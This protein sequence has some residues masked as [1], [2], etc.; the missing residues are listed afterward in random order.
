M[1]RI[2]DDHSSTVNSVAQDLFGSG[3]DGYN[4]PLVNARPGTVVKAD[5]MNA[6]QNEIA[7][8]I[9]G[10]DTLVDGNTINLIKGDRA[11]L[12]ATLVHH[13]SMNYRAITFDTLG[14]DRLFRGHFELTGGPSSVGRFVIVGQNAQI[15]VSRG[16]LVWDQRVADGAFGGN[17]F[18]VGFDVTIGLWCIVGDSDEIQTSPDGQTWTARTA[19]VGGAFRGVAGTASNTLF[20]AVGVSGIQESS[21][22]GIAWTDRSGATA[23]S[24]VDVATF[25]GSFIAVG[26]NGTIVHTAEGTPGGWATTPAAGG[27][28]GFFRGVASS[29]TR[30]VAVG[31][32]GEIQ[33]SDNVTTWTQANVSAFP[34]GVDWK[35]VEHNG[36]C[37]VVVGGVGATDQFVAVSIDGDNWTVRTLPFDLVEALNVV[38]S[39]V[40]T[41]ITGN[42]A[43][44]D[45]LAS[46]HR[47]GLVA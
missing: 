28:T 18:G 7:N 30:A 16:G 15:Q 12:A 9:V 36:R 11:Q 10:G 34:A 38:S 1:H 8:L 6:V 3:K 26:D 2:I 35:K 42:I 27:Y 4:E 41:V 5:H 33:F 19:A 24:L 46:V 14:T 29:P 43:T 22:N 25:S 37:F 45:G 32:A 47:M 23:N 44:V 20:Q 17:F 13:Q 21:A 40:S 31:D 39:D